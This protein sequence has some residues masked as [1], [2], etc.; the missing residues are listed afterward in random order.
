MLTILIGLIV[1]VSLWSL[2]GYVSSRVEQTDYIVLKKTA[3]YEIR[4]YPAHIVAQATVKGSYAE[5][6]N[7][8]FGIVARYIF[9]G[10]IK[11]ERISMTSP[12]VVEQE[13]GMKISEKIAMTAPVVSTNDGD[14]QTVSFGMPKAYSLEI[15]PTPTDPRVKIEVI[16][17]KRF[18]VRQFSGYRSD[19]RI[20]DQ[21]EKL[22][23]ALVR[24]GVKPE[25]G[26][27]YAGYSA[28]WTPPWMCRNEVMVEIGE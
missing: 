19:A 9:G 11:K 26:M 18:A 6:L 14:S 13:T 5:S 24:D 20:K 21:Q 17:K 4:E 10:N 15:L 12:V 28:P 1:V 2:W 7:A 25:G 8:G 27:S 22:L 3:D 23:A 16:P